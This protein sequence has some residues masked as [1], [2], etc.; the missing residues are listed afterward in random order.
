[1]IST[2]LRRLDRQTLLTSA[3]TGSQAIFLTTAAYSVDGA[4][5]DEVGDRHPETYPIDCG[6][7]DLDMDPPV[8][9]DDAGWLVSYCWE[10]AIPFDPSEAS[11]RRQRS[12]LSEN[13]ALAAA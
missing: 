9:Y 1:M 2:F 4:G 7:D 3:S 6:E 8:M 11:W 12:T 5:A 13:Q 10:T